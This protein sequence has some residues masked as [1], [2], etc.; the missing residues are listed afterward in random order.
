MFSNPSKSVLGLT[1]NHSTIK[2]GRS[3]GDEALS[4]SK[5]FSFLLVLWFFQSVFSLPA[6]TSTLDTTSA[7]ETTISSV[8]ASTNGTAFNNSFSSVLAGGIREIM[9]THPTAEICGVNAIGDEMH[10][11]TSTLD[12]KN[13]AIDF[14]VGITQ[15]VMENDR[16]QWDRWD[17]PYQD[18]FEVHS[19]L[20]FKMKDLVIKADSA[21]DRI[22]G[23]GFEDP[24][25]GVD[26][27]FDQVE[28]IPG[29][30][31]VYSFDLQLDADHNYRI[32]VDAEN[33]RVYYHDMSQ[34][35]Y[36]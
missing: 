14:Q 19:D 20:N 34:D 36:R 12:L 7:E 16:H 3:I 18:S 22:R 13:I 11:V 5:L 9:R 33:G 26:I 10:P 15:W 28:K 4:M 2:V 1:A 32:N 17:A 21:L 23:Y 27:W 25:I 30:R 6:T 31:L 24:I 8:K 29:W 35:T